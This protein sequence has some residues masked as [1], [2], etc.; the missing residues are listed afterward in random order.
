MTKLREHI[1][2]FENDAGSVEL[3]LLIYLTR[4]NML[5]DPNSDDYDENRVDTEEFFAKNSNTSKLRQLYLEKYKLDDKINEL[6]EDAGWWKALDYMSDK[7]LFPESISL[8]VRVDI[9]ERCLFY[10]QKTYGRVDPLKLMSMIELIDWAAEQ[11]NSWYDRGG[12]DD[13][14]PIPID[15]PIED[16]D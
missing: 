8:R 2:L 16:V 12:D 14:D 4:M 7:F 3:D 10:F 9:M 15:E 1:K 5:I 11:V 13:D 6:V